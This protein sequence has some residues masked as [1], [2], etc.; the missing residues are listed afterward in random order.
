VSLNAVVRD[1]VTRVPPPSRSWA[2]YIAVQ[3]RGEPDAVWGG[4]NAASVAYGRENCLQ[5]R[6]FLQ[7][8]RDLRGM[9]ETGGRLRQNRQQNM[10]ICRVFLTG[11]TGL[12]PA[13]SGV[14]G[15]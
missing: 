3:R 10:P 12:E 6:H 9:K 8:V 15:R 2:A 13:T 11:A 1:N 4:M 5:T 14:T 7:F